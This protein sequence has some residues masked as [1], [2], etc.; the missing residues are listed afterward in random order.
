M[1]TK[2]HI[3]YCKYQTEIVNQKLLESIHLKAFFVWCEPG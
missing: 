3:R 2:A 1:K